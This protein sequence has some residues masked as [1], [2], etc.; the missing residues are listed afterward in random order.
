M[1][2]GMSF[3]LLRFRDFV[4][5][6]SSYSFKTI[7]LQLISPGKPSTPCRSLVAVPREPLPVTRDI[8]VAGKGLAVAIVA[9]IIAEREE[10]ESSAFAV[11]S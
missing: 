8:R 2:Y 10:S 11:P 5:V 6:A 4:V 7:R 9:M 1:S 3:S